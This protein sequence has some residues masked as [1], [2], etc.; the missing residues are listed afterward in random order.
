VDSLITTALDVVA[1]AVVA[2]GVCW[3]LWPHIGG[4]ALIPAG[5]VVAGGSWYAEHRAA[6]ASASRS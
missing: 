6:K 4:F 1:L 2:V 3:G 5:I